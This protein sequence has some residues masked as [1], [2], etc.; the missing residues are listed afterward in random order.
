MDITIQPGCESWQASG[1][2]ATAST[3]VVIVHGFTGNPLATTPLGRHVNEAGFSVEVLRLP[4][5]GTS[6][7]DFTTSRYADYRRVVDEAVTR[8]VDTADRVVL[9]GH[10]MGGSLVLDVGS[11]RADEIVG[12]VAINPQIQDPEQLLAKLAPLLQ[13]VLPVVPRDL[14]GLPTNDVAMPGVAEGAYPKVSAKAAQSFIAALPGIRERLPQLTVPLLIITAP[15]DHTVPAKNSDTVAE[16]AG[17]TV[18]RVTAE[19]SYHV[20][21]LDWDRDLVEASVADFVRA[22]HDA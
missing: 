12:V 17:G 7:K 13:H 20:P 19:R 15:Q 1:V 14:A 5:H 18:T 9:V 22:R 16:L 8:A 21:Q 4:G 2:G 3:A 6:V 10:S 11:S